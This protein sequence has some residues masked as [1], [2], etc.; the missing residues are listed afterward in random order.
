[1]IR[2]GVVDIGI[3]NLGSLIGALARLEA[4]PNRVETASDLIGVNHLI[5]PGV[6]TFEGGITRLAAAGLLDPIKE[7]AQKGKA[8]LGICLG[9]QLLADTGKEGGEIR[10]LG[11]VNGTVGMMNP[12]EGIRI[13]HIGWNS[14]E[15]IGSHA[16]LS[17]I[18]EGADF[19]FVH[20]YSFS[21]VP[22]SSVQATT[23][24]GSTFPSVVSKGSVL[25]V[26]FHPEKSQKNG[27]RLLSN[28]LEWNPT[29]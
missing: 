21:G 17:G 7:Y 1:M 27:L 29:C 25:G 13:P 10:G 20:G 3:S 28:F 12:S 8:L 18:S 26:Q 4:V 14:V 6:G 24:H 2:V 5:M 19:Y 23:N 11:L 15:N 9:M 16:L 22:E